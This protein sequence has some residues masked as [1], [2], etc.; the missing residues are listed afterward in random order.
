MTDHEHPQAGG[1]YL[2]GKDGKL[3]RIDEAAPPAEQPAPAAEPARPAT[4]AGSTHKK[5][6]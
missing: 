1:S 4:K 2:R 6:K 5:E 3:T